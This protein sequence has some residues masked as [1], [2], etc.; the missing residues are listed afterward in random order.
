[1][2]NSIANTY[3]PAELWEKITS[4]LGESG[5]SEKDDGTL[6]M[7]NKELYQIINTKY[8]NINN[9]FLHPVE[10]V[11]FPEITEVD[12]KNALCSVKL[13]IL[14]SYNK[15]I[16]AFLMVAGGPTCDPQLR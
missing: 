14:K 11:L 6:G 15:Q 2:T 5:I 3:I 12:N 4:F 13:G 10:P 9:Y 8:K 1:M 16:S 7:V